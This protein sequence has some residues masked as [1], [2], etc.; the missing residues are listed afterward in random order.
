MTRSTRSGRRGGQPAVPMATADS[1]T[2]ESTLSRK[3]FKHAYLA[4]R[5]QYTVARPQLVKGNMQLFSVDQQSSQALEAHAASFATFKVPVNENPSK[6]ICFA[7]KSS[8]AG[9]ITS[10]LHITELCAQTERA[11]TF[12]AFLLLSSSLLD[13]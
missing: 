7:S 8:N 1:V 5:I 11:Y 12:M 9:Q 3:D 10:K 2:D 6:L 13:C 4:S